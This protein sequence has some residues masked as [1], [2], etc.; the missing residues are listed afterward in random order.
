[1]MRRSAMALGVWCV[2]GLMACGTTPVTQ[3]SFDQAAL[4]QDDGAMTTSDELP[5]EADEVSDPE[6]SATCCPH[7]S[8]PMTCIA[9]TPRRGWSVVMTGPHRPHWYRDG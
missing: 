2:L 8:N 7:C 5:S 3:V 9:S 4:E 1:M 6:A